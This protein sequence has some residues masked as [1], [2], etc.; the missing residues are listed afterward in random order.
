MMDLSAY[1]PTKQG[2]QE[3]LRVSAD[4]IHKLWKAKRARHT[5]DLVVIIDTKEN[6]VRLEPRTKTCAKLKRHNPK[7]SLLDSLER[8]APG[9]VGAISLWCITGFT[10]GP[11]F[12]SPITIAQN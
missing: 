8:P 3:I 9:P 2:T 1:P 12:V 7:I 6:T 11:V 10:Q 4:T 5:D